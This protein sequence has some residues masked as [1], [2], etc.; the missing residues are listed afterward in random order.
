VTMKNG[1]FIVFLFMLMYHTGYSQWVCGDTL[2]DVRDGKKYPTVQIGSQC[3]M[4]ANLDIGTRIIGTKNPSDNDTIEKYC[5]GDNPDSC[6]VHGG[7]YTW[8][9]M[10][11]YTTYE[12][13]RGICPAGWHIPSDEEI[14]ELE[15]TLG[16][17]SATAELAN[18]WRGTD[19][20][21]Q[22]K[23]GGSSGLNIMLSGAR[24]STGSYMAINSYAYIYSST[25]SGT[26]AWRRC[27]RT[28]D[29]QVG[30]FNTFPKTYGFSVRCVKGDDTTTV[31][32]QTQL[33]QGTIYYYQEGSDL[34][35]FCNMT[36]EGDVIISIVDLSGKILYAEKKFITPFTNSVTLSAD[37]LSQGIYIVHLQSALNVMTGKIVIQ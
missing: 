16:M 17:D 18:V 33:P 2:T 10:M 12:G 28:Y 23:V 24:V 9:E 14:K 15:R 36:H 34:V 31:N 1:F 6:L 5:W 35:L 25:E 27:V 21:T 29:T 30:R 20:G 11:D 22:M 32:S 8:D 37:N 19:Q 3:W 26:N 4:A 7:L 13:S